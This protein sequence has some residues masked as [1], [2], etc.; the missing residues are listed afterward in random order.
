MGSA[1]VDGCDLR[2][3]RITGRRTTGTGSSARQFRPAAPPG[4]SA[5]QLCRSPGPARLLD[6]V[7]GRSTQAFQTWLAARDQV[8]R[9]LSRG[10]VRPY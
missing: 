5:R 1:A 3:R 6:M 4:S 8:W 10:C 2:G 7:E 9:A